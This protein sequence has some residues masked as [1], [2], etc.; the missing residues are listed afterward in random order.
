MTAMRTE[1]TLT[2]LLTHMVKRLLNLKEKH[3]A[4]GLAALIAVGIVIWVSTWK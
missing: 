2:A 3:L 1:R 4:V